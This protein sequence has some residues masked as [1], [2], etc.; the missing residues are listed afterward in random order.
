MKDG[1]RS[2]LKI[3]ISVMLVKKC[4]LIFHQNVKIEARASAQLKS[5]ILQNVIKTILELETIICQVFLINDETLKNNVPSKV[6]FLIFV[7]FY[8]IFHFLTLIYIFIITI[9]IMKHSLLLSRPS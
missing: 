9:K 7:N 8:V 6:N 5:T 2:N 3:L 4:C 1:K